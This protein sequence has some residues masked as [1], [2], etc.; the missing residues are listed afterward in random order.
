MNGM[1][2]SQHQL[3]TI[4]TIS[5]KAEGEEM[6]RAQYSF[7]PHSHVPDSILKYLATAGRSL[8]HSTM[9]L[10][11]DYSVFRSNQEAFNQEVWS[12]M[13]K[14]AEETTNLRNWKGIMNEFGDCVAWATGA[15]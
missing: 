9:K 11:W 8:E 1:T 2:N 10:A 7:D 5:S 4:S 15:S 13:A 14:I 6:G 12:N 3:A